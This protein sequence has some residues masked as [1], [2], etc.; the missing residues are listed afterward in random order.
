[1]IFR[2]VLAASILISGCGEVSSEKPRKTRK[3]RL[4]A[5]DAVLNQTPEPRTYRIDG[6]ELKVIEV[7]TSGVAGYVSTQRCL[8]WR[9]TE[10][11]SV[12]MSC[13]AAPGGMLVGE[14]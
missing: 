6:N 12:T 7:P 3:D 9:D 5:A 11:R 1:M 4:E 8:V 14:D 2:L 10:F 13:P